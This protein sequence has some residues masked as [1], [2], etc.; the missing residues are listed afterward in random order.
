[1]E[2]TYLGTAAAEGW[3]S[4]FCECNA[5]VKAKELGGKN[6]RTRSQAVIDGELLIDFPPDTY[7][8]FLYGKLDLNK[9][10]HIF[11]THSHWDHFY[12]Q[13]IFMRSDGYGDFNR[14]K[15]LHIYGNQ[16]VYDGLTRLKDEE[17][18]MYKNLMAHCEFHVLG[19]GGQI[20]A[21]GYTVTP[22]P[23]DH[24]TQA[25]EQ[26]F[27]YLI[28]KDGAALLYANDTGYLTDGAWAGLAGKK[29]RFVSLDCTNLLNENKRQHMGLAG[30]AEVKQRMLDE[31]MADAKTCF[32]IHHFSH[33]GGGSLLH[34]ELEQEAGK[35]GFNVSY[36]GCT[37]NI[38][39][40][41]L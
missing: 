29:L 10:S 32:Y 23:A 19:L 20:Q 30:C 1:M 13:D 15:T 9:I 33:N 26:A 38:K 8:H 22:L 40:I 11:I 17:S 31:G 34:A 35:Y 41:A 7:M 21:G 16:A 37:V 4:L 5:C 14:N 36:D 39:P 12:P 2:F 6:I 25:Q 24:H 28:E 18:H 27:I 3:P